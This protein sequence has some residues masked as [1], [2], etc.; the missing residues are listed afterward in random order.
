MT[1]CGGGGVG[2]AVGRPHC[3]WCDARP[4]DESR[5]I[6]DRCRR[7]GGHSFAKRSQ[8]NILFSAN[9]SSVSIIIPL[10]LN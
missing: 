8:L 1:W 9:L 6:S 4:S 7:G 3:P 5:T 10:V 2:G